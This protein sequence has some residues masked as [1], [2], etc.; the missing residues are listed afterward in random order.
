MGKVYTKQGDFDLALQYQNDAYEYARN[1]DNKLEEARAP[2]WGWPIPT[3]KKNNTALALAYY[4]KAQT[5]ANEIGF[6]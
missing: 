3:R 6:K 1:S 2:F 4:T 5:I